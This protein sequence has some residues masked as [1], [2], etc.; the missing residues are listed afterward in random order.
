MTQEQS[1]SLLYRLRLSGG[2]LLILCSLLLIN[3]PSWG[4]NAMSHDR[5][6]LEYQQPARN[7]WEALPLGNGFIGAMVYGGTTHERIDLNETTFWS[8][9]PYNNDAPHA[10]D[11]LQW[12][13]ELIRHGKEDQAE[14]VINRNF[15]TGKNGMRFLPLGSLLIDMPT[16]AQTTDP[17]QAKSAKQTETNGYHR[18]LSLNEAVNTTTF[19]QN[20][21]KIERKAFTSFAGRFMA[22]HLQA[23]RKGALQFSVALSS[24]LNHEVKAQD[25]QIT[26]VC[27]GE[28]QEGVKAGLHA[29]T[30]VAVKSD[31]KIVCKDNRLCISGA[32]SAT[33]Y[34]TAAT[35][36]VNYH[37]ISG[38][39]E[40]KAQ[41][42]LEQA[43]AGNYTQQLRAHIAAYQPL[44][45]KVDLS[46]NSAK[47]Q[48][49]VLPTDVLLQQYPQQQNPRLV[50][51]MFQYG[52]YLLLSSSRSGGQAANLQGIW[53]K[54][55]NAPWDSKYTININ[56]EMNYWPA[57][58]TNL[59]S[60]L[61]PLF[62]LISDLSQT[63]ARTA[64]TMYGCRGFVA[65]HNTDIWR[66]AGPIDGAYWG[67][68]PC[69]G[70]WLTTH[71]WQHYLFT[72]DKSFLRQW[73]PVLRS[74]A[75]FLMDYGQIVPTD[76][77]YQFNALHPT[78]NAESASADSCSISFNT[79]H[80]TFNIHKAFLLSPSVSPEHGPMGKRTSVTA[81]CTMDNQI[82]FDALS[83]AIKASEILGTD[84]TFRHEAQEKLALLPPM[85][86]GRYGQLQEW[87]QDG[88]NPK[89]EHRHISHLYGLYPSNQIS[90]F[91]H[92]ELFSAAH[93]TLLQR[94]DMATGW[95][96]GWKINFWARMLDGDHAL[97][98]INNLLHLLPCDSLQRQYPNGRVYPNLFD[99]HPPFQI[100]GNFGFTA[101]IAEM[102][103]QSH[104]GAVHLL[105]ALPA[106][107]HEG[108]VKGIRTR[109][110]FVVSE[111]WSDGKLKS[112]TITSTIG[113]VLRLRAYQP[114]KGQ[115]L[116]EAKG[117]C[118]NALF[119]P[120][121]VRQPIIHTEKVEEVKI[122]R[123]YEYDID[124]QPGKSYAVFGIR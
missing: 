49:K 37:D 122:P 14:G 53:N 82:A 60:T 7:W 59:T 41:Q 71:L 121:V 76:S 33:I 81:G 102:L 48:E 15:F 73:Y 88:D 67:M 19:Y 45:N 52:R 110:G 63:G 32:T 85:Q 31:G 17:Q 24:I 22:V 68:F 11:S 64:Q 124:T 44:F 116:R 78:H 111:Q 26:M 77:L 66:V 23:S 83:S 3:L 119:A 4:R 62:A 54:E 106:A 91:S 75:R 92:P 93:T 50:T 51:L 6:C 56:T 1:H 105:P 30:K 87:L 29:V 42:A 98:I 8:G 115:G 101:G 10:K 36:F 57:E 2:L 103:V 96:L 13:R 120:A 61:P 34:L 25:Q 80:S 97:Q 117:A 28:N 12:V 35:N 27:Q 109:G 86:V 38:N 112:A 90:P 72:G 70:A 46:I 55:R 9:S 69:G 74:A 43:I 79:H 95:S 40:D 104:D 47:S 113:G 99:A 84:T 18:L 123:V 16:D 108:N 114:L 21:I 65:H 5:L 20:G 100:D 58:V 118:P 107:W 94:G 39:A 89:D